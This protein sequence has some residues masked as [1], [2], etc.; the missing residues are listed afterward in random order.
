[1]KS[2]AARYLQWKAVLTAAP[3]DKDGP[4]LISV[5]VGYQQRNARPHVTSISV[6]PPGATF[7]RP[8]PTGEP[9][10]AGLGE[11]PADAK[12]PVFSL[13]LGSVSLNPSS[14]P[15]M[16]R[17][18]YQKGLQ[19]FTWKAD[20]D[21]EDRLQYEV[22]YRSV[23][24]AAWKPLRHVTSEQVFTWD[25]TSVP[26]GTYLIKVIAS[27][28]LSN[29]PGAALT[30]ELESDTFDIDNT[31][32]SISVAQIT[33]DGARA[34]VVIEVRDAQSAVGTVEYSMD[35]DRWQTL[36]PTDGIADAKVE[37]YEM[38]VDAD[39]L[40]RLVIR[41]ADALNN[42]ATLKVDAPR[43]KSK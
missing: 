21:N 22:L 8:F 9:E 2:P 27:D 28:A 17:R 7:Q 29:A 38:K 14:G 19:T 3:A 36:F 32:P 37:R 16:G 20:D 30:G 31:P 24:G 39:M 18:L 12:P 35:G 1:M 13:P 42:I 23:D 10:I 40:G 26:D 25:T 15:P 6:L 5:R 34:T 43:D 11:T 33:R 4:S 41:A